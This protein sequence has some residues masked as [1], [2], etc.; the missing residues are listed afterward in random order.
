[1]ELEAG[2]KL[3]QRPKSEGRNSK[4]GRRPKL[5]SMRISPLFGSVFGFLSAFGDSAFGSQTQEVR[6]AGWTTFVGR[7]VLPQ[8]IVTT[9]PSERK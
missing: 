4:E 8:G 3:S 6:T 7:L 2:P 1:M 9:W 5:E